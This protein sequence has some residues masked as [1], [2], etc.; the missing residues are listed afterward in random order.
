LDFGIAPR[1]CYAQRKTT[2]ISIHSMP[3]QKNRQNNLRK[4]KERGTNNDLLQ[5]IH[6]KLKIE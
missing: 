3:K 5:N 4:K 2:K 6:L 1:V